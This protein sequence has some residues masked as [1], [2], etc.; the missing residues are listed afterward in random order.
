MIGSSSGFRK[1]NCFKQTN[2]KKM[3]KMQE[4]IE[5]MHGIVK[6]FSFLDM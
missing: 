6:I 3:Q 5:K 2:K 1:L 4:K